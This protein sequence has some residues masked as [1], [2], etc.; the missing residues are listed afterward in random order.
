MG[1]TILPL[2]PRHLP[3]KPPQPIR[4]INQIEMADIH[5]CPLVLAPFAARHTYQAVVRTFLLAHDAVGASESGPDGR[6]DGGAVGEIPV[7]SG[8]RSFDFFWERGKARC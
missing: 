3:H 6:G 2:I 4:P 8:M 1:D 5:Q 7:R